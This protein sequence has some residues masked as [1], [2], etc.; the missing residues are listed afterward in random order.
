VKDEHKSAGDRDEHP[1]TLPPRK[2]RAAFLFLLL[3]SC[4]L[5]L[6]YYRLLDQ[7]IEAVRYPWGLLPAHFLF[8][9][10]FGQLST[11]F[12]VAI[13]SAFLWAFFRPSHTRQLLTLSTVALLI[14]AVAFAAYAIAL[15]GL[16]LR[17]P[18]A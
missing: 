13:A 18:A 8:L 16:L 10:Y 3:L 7:G 11:C 14:F 6:L 2:A 1:A 15:L 9:R 4:A 5:P 12:P 17:M